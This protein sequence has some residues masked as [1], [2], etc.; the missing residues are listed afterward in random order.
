MSG[1]TITSKANQEAV[2]WSENMSFKI[3]YIGPVLLK[4]LVTN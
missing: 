2:H 3:Q 4:L 1:C